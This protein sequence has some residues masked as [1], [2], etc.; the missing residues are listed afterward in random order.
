M[1]FFGKNFDLTLKNFWYP[2]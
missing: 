2:F 1:T